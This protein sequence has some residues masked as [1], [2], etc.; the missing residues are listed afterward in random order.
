MKIHRLILAALV[1]IPLAAACDKAQAG[2]SP[3]FNLPPGYAFI[4]D[5]PTGIA[6]RVDYEAKTVCVTDDTHPT[7][8]AR[9]LAH[10]L[11]HAWA[12]EW[13]VNPAHGGGTIDLANPDYLI[14][15]WIAECGVEALG[16]PPVMYLDGV[17]FS[18][19]LSLRCPPEYRELGQ[20]LAFWVSAD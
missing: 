9:R 3:E 12:E 8:V 17:R 4:G 20:A 15:E 7:W 10:E 1:L 19:H 14:G 13:G 18:M 6:G 16:Y 2:N 11:V 5:C